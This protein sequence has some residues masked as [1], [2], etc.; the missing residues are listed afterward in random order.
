MPATSEDRKIFR[1]LLKAIRR[2]DYSAEP[3][4]E[5]VLAVGVS[6]L[7]TPYVSN[8]LE[9]DG[10]EKLIINLRQ[11]DCFTFVENVVTLARLVRSGGGSFRDFISA[12]EN[13]R[14]RKGVLNGYAS[15][16]HYFSDWLYDNQ[17]KG[18]L[19][20]ISSMAG[21]EPFVKKINFMTSNRIMYP[22]LQSEMEFERMLVTENVCSR[23]N[24]YYIPNAKL[25]AGA[26]K[27]KNGDLIGITTNIE[28]L[29]VLHTGI[30]VQFKR[31]LHLLHAS[32]KEG[33]VIISGETLYRYLNLRKS[34]S[35]L[36]VAR[37]L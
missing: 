36:M 15:R 13:I 23:H 34:R 16:L 24:L 2:Q 37:A 14:Y 12:L 33:R 21:G 5:L 17:E 9:C 26:E 18:I 8:T 25:K 10:R 7:G 31:G 20:D 1:N 28:G 6:F 4:G 29:D 19:K 30:A 32:S 22:A 35:G 27:I 11:L 3:L